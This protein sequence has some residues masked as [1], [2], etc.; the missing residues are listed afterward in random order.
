[1]I[2]AAFNVHIVYGYI[3]IYFETL[4]HECKWYQSEFITFPQN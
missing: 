4:V 1:M 3:L 2:I